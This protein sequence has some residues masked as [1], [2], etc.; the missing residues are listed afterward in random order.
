[1]RV[2]V[3]NP[4]TEETKNITRDLIYGSWCKGKRIGGTSTPP[5]NLLYVATVLKDGGIDVDFY[6]AMAEQK[7]PETKRYD[8]VVI[9]TST[10]SFKSDVR[11]LQKLKKENP[12]IKTVVFGSHPTFMPKFCLSEEAVD[13]IALR[14][15]EYVIKD[16][17]LA[18]KKG[19]DVS[20]VKGIGYKD[21]KIKINKPHEFIKD[22]DDMPFPDRTMLPDDIDYFNPI[23][24]RLPYTTT[25]TSRGCPSVCTYCNVPDFYGKCL[26]FRSAENVI[27]EIELIVKQ[28]YR[29]IWFRDETFTVFKK[30]NEKICDYLI[31]NDVD[32][33]WICNARIGT[34]TKESMRKMKKAGCHMIKFGVESGVQRI[35]DNVKKNIKIT[36]TRKTFRW[37]HEV[38]I[39]THAHVMLGMPGENKKTVNQTINFIKEIDP[40][41]ATFGICTPYAGTPLFEEVKKKD[42]SIKDGSSIDLSKLHTTGLFNKYFTDLSPEEL[43]RYER[44][45]Y[46][47]FYLRPSY[48]LKWLG[49]IKS[50]D[51]F[52]RVTLAATNV[53]SFGMGN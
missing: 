25:M 33:T 51:E 40:T 5:L 27:K 41:T 21:E 12:C 26:R 46:R 30:R 47:K 39:D 49:R 35:L 43:E 38:G 7:H 4:F 44:M 36:N 32:I 8:A 2:L 24:K 28:G 48:I 20:K 9:S 22:L 6:D 45:A 18:L 11:F 1:M 52:K 37:A 3:I 53:F 42:P 14:E 34:V 29:E 19:K 15:P 23:I 13:F 10:M 16:L 31:D 17:I 50:V